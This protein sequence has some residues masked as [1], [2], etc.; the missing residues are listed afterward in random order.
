MFLAQIVY[1]VYLMYM[2]VYVRCKVHSV[3]CM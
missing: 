2:G 1:S 3:E